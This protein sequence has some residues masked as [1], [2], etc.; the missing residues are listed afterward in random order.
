V[1]SF[2][3]YHRHA[4]EQCAVAYAA[5][6]GIDSPLHGQ[7]FTSSCLHGGHE[8]WWRV[9]AADP[10]AALALL[11]EWLAERTVATAV[12]DGATG[13]AAGPSGPSG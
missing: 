4:A 11:P 6:K 9:D 7:R 2:L 8:I 5:W 13:T 1:P 3:L 12:A 10:A